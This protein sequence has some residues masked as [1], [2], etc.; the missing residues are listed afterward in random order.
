VRPETLFW[1]APSGGNTGGGMMIFLVQMG[2]IVAIFYFLIIRPKV[3]Q[4]KRHRERLKEIKKGDRIVTA[5][6]IIGEVVHL[7][8][9]EITLRSGE[10]RLVVQRDRVADILSDKTGAEA[11]S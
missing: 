3:Q 1:F 11:K 9:D 7:K 6:G 2:A 5:G 10:S 4:E 8:D